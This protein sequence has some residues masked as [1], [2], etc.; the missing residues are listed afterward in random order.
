MSTEHADKIAEFPTLT[1]FN[2]QSYRKDLFPLLNQF[3][4][5]GQEI[6]LNERV[7]LKKPMKT[8]LVME[9]VRDSETGEVRKVLTLWSANQKVNDAAFHVKRA[10]YQRRKEK[11]KR[12]AGRLFPRLFNSMNAAVRELVRLRREEYEKVERRCDPLGLFRLMM[13]VCQVY[14]VNNLPKLESNYRACVWYPDRQKLSQHI[15]IVEAFHDQL[16]TA[17]RELTDREKVSQ[18]VE[19]IRYTAKAKHPDVIFTILPVLNTKADDPEFPTYDSIRE[20]L[21]NLENSDAGARGDPRGDPDGEDIDGP[22]SRRSFD[23]AVRQA[24][25]AEVSKA[26]AVM[27]QDPGKNFAFHPGAPPAPG[28]DRRGG[29]DRGGGGQPGRANGG[30]GR[31]RGDGGQ[32]GGPTGGRGHSTRGQ[33]RDQGGRGGGQQPFKRERP[34]WNCGSTA[35]LMANCDSSKAARCGKCGGG[36]LTQFH[37]DVP[38]QPPAKRLKPSVRAV[39]AVNEN[40]VRQRFQV[41]SDSE[42]SVSVRMIMARRGDPDAADEDQGETQDQQGTALDTEAAPQVI[43]RPARKQARPKRLVHIPQGDRTAGGSSAAAGEDDDDEYADDDEYFDEDDDV[44][45]YYDGA[46]YDGASDSGVPYLEGSDGERDY[47]VPAP[48]L[49][50]SPTTLLGPALPML[51]PNRGCAATLKTRDGSSVPAR[52]FNRAQLGI[53]QPTSTATPPSGLNSLQRL[54]LPASGTPRPP[55][56]MRKSM[57]SQDRER[58]RLLKANR[59]MPR[60]LEV[61]RSPAEDNFEL[62]LGVHV[63]NNTE[64]YMHRLQHAILGEGMTGLLPGVN[65]FAHNFQTEYTP[66]RRAQI[67]LPRT[68]NYDEI[69]DL[70][71]RQPLPRVGTGIFNFRRHAAIL[72]AVR[73]YHDDMLRHQV[74]DM[75]RLQDV[76]EEHQLI[77]REF[78]AQHWADGKKVPL[79]TAMAVNQWEL[80]GYYFSSPIHAV[81]HP[82]EAG[83]MLIVQRIPLD[84]RGNPPGNPEFC[85]PFAISGPRSNC[86]SRDTKEDHVLDDYNRASTQRIFTRH[87]QRELLDS[88][89]DLVC[90]HDDTYPTFM[91]P[92]PDVTAPPPPRRRHGTWEFMF[93]DGSKRSFPV[94]EKLR[95]G[96][97]RPLK[98]L[99]SAHEQL[100]LDAEDE[101]PCPDLPQ[102]PHPHEAVTIVDEYYEALFRRATEERRRGPKFSAQQVIGAKR[103]YLY[104]E[105]PATKPL[106]RHNEPPPPPPPALPTSS[107]AAVRMITVAYPQRAVLTVRRS[108]HRRDMVLV[109]SG[110]SYNI[111]PTRG[112]NADLYIPNNNQVRMTVANGQDLNVTHLADVPGLGLTVVA[113]ASDMTIASTHQLAEQG[114]VITHD[115]KGFQAKRV[116]G[117]LA[118]LRITHPRRSQHV[119]GYV[120]GSGHYLVT[121]ADY[122]SLALYDLL[123]TSRDYLRNTGTDQTGEATAL[124]TA[125]ETGTLGYYT[126]EQQ[127]RAHELR[128]LHCTLGHP[129]DKALTDALDNGTLIGTHLTSRDVPNAQAILGQCPGCIAGKTVKPSYRSSRDE[130]ASAVGQVLHADIFPLTSTAGEDVYGGGDV[131]LLVVD[132]YS[133]YLS[134]VIMDDKST[135][136][137]IKA[138]NTILATYAQFHHFTEEVHTDSESNLKSCHQHLNYLGIVHQASP[139]YQHS[140]RVERHTRTLRQRMDCM[141]A[142]A[143]IVIEPKLEGELAQAAA[144][145]IN[146]FPT[147]KHPTRS[148]RMLVEGTKLKLDHRDK[149]IPFGTVAQ[150]LNR[151]DKENRSRTAIVLGPAPMTQHAYNCYVLETEKRVVRACNDIEV[152]TRIPDSFAGKVKREFRNKQIA[153]DTTLLKNVRKSAIKIPTAPLQIR[154]T[155]TRT[156]EVSAAAVP[157]PVRAATPPPAQPAKRARTT[158]S[159]TTSAREGEN[160]NTGASTAKALD[161]ASA[162]ASVEPQPQDP[163]LDDDDY[164]GTDETEAQKAHEERERKRKRAEAVEAEREVNV[165]KA[166]ARLE[167]RYRKQ[168]LLDKA[169]VMKPKN[170]RDKITAMVALTRTEKRLLRRHWKNTDMRLSL[171]TSMALR[172]SVKEALGGEHAQES[173]EA[174]REEIQNMLDYKVGHYVRFRDIPVAKR[175]NILQSFMFLKHKTTPD[176]LYERTKSRMVANGATQPDHMYNLVSSTTVGLASVFLMFNIATMYKCKLSSYDIKGAFLHAEFGDDDEVTY[177]KINKEITRIWV[178]QDPS[179]AEFVD[180]RGELLLELDKFIYG[181]KQSPLKFQAHLSNVLLGMGYKKMHHDECM[182]VK[183]DGEHFSI[184]AVHVDDILQASTAEHLYKEL[185]EGLQTAYGTITAHENAEAYLGMT[186]ERS[187]C[188]EYLKITQK[189]MIQKLVEK[190]PALSSDRKKY[191]TPAV[192]EIFD[193]RASDHHAALTDKERSQYLGLVMTLMYLARLSRP[194]IL[195]PVTFLASRTHVST[196]KDLEHAMR[197]IRYLEHT[198]DEGL[199]IHCDDL[200]ITVHCDASFMV[201]RDAGR[202]H[203]G[204]YVTLGASRSYVHGR[205][206]KQKFAA[207]SST[208]SEIIAALDAVKFAVWMRNLLA[209][210]QITPLNVMTLLQDSKSAIMLESNPSNKRSAHM[211]SKLRYVE[212]QIKNGSLVVEHVATEMLSADLLTKPLQ[213]QLFVEHRDCMMGGRWRDKMHAQ[214]RR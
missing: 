152:M 162:Q 203:T 140:Q 199:I 72:T 33:P 154:R 62:E 75:P 12:D 186:I 7:K 55:S 16:V 141:R 182:Y 3:G 14:S 92:T 51:T 84:E 52:T 113:P 177:I 151:E 10:T 36:H 98:Q 48:P 153:M 134:L 21:L 60:D 163:N 64:D 120:T 207:T 29:R 179:S 171:L 172:I 18:L 185:N 137:L 187:S 15:T 178:E 53:G 70:I 68:R 149:L 126:T 79:R 165:A 77:F 66:G 50:V 56:P 138:F 155:I 63:T 27:A 88:A 159:S 164:F 144:K 115:H 192:E 170:S 86:L 47:S 109:D 40:A 106:T 210:L 59:P 85:I 103:A 105:E 116:Q 94:P 1:E 128:L 61:A 81:P 102:E 26:L 146:D 176:G 95:N 93:A 57:E 54:V 125:A 190:Y 76:E 73:W 83:K 28:N 191:H 205:S 183:H 148:P 167:E 143:P 122:E 214:R 104:D 25:K 6:Y 130:P 110:S 17:G 184:L 194:D 96:T 39:R 211:T 24:A 101:L 188:M 45:G 8:T 161:N 197:V 38:G 147:T 139:P 204:F 30:R 135:A 174:I 107:S 180:D 31:G 4:D 166:A 202:G 97:M 37:D 198:I 117:Q 145:Y 136:N 23:K 208:E 111:E 41:A 175:R 123:P 201:H 35:H 20:K 108:G 195:L 19:G 129:S 112:E 65:L 200:S 80:E 150:I 46:E 99:L 209:E 206:G 82:N 34:C 157:T 43:S 42:D 100:Q 169:P 78:Y 132:E 114:C 13:E 5:K 181:L 127:V 44:D 67:H 121:R 168:Q 193:T 160:G 74:H 158:R 71:L 91:L 173:A 118:V 11:R 213:G 196:V 9:K 90:E 49:H 22:R 58:A 212:D 89:A 69:R 124:A 2:A 119:Y 87:E 133:G 131:A 142:T 189:G 32:R 156:A